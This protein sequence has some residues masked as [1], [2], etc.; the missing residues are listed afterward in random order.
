MGCLIEHPRRLGDPSSV[1][2]VTPA[3]RKRVVR[4]CHDV[5]LQPGDVLHG[6]LAELMGGGQDR[7]R[8]TWVA[9]PVSRA[10][11]VAAGLAGIELPVRGSE[12][13]DLRT[14][15]TA[16]DHGASVIDVAVS[17]NRVHVL[18]PAVSGTGRV[19]VLAVA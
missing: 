16:Q 11:P 2:R 19:I 15:D 3:S 7:L 9:G 17:R 1:T 8:V 12:L 14:R 4:V 6:T 18:V 13:P 10:L 5:L